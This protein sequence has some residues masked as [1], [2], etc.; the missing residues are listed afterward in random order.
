MRDFV[1]GI[2][3]LG[4]DGQV[5]IVHSLI[6]KLLVNQKQNMTDAIDLPRIT[7]IIITTM[8]VVTTTTIT[9]TTT[10]TIVPSTLNIYLV[11]VN[12]CVDI[13]IYV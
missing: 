8:E 13:L 1:L 12:K 5:L 6:T 9:T 3:N 2:T 4:D 11:F 7:T 10:D